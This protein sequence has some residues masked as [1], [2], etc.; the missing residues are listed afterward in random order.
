MTL[1]EEYTEKC[2]IMFKDGEEYAKREVS[3]LGEV[4]RKEV[5]KHGS[6]TYFFACGT[7]AYI[8][9]FRFRLA[10]GDRSLYDDTDELEEE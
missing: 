4:V 7:S 5:D 1:T 3:E 6:I 2:R 10:Q 9:I 8:D